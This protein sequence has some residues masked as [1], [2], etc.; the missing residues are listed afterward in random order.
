MLPGVAEK[1]GRIVGGSGRDRWIF[2][3]SFRVFF[4]SMNFYIVL[5][6]RDFRGE[7]RFFFTLVGDS[8]GESVIYIHDMKEA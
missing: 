2:S 8:Y 3:G 7:V 5:L 6:R 4:C 1:L